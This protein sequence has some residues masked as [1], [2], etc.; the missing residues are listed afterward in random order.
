MSRRRNHDERVAVV[1]RDMQMLPNNDRAASALLSKHV[2]SHPQPCSACSLL[3]PAQISWNKIAPVDG[4]AT[5]CAF[6][7][8]AGRGSTAVSV[9]YGGL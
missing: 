1:W 7:I 6:I 2:P 9:A 3:F 4:A 8:L 5:F